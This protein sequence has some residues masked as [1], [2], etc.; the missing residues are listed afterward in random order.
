MILQST[1]RIISIPRVEVERYQLFSNDSLLFYPIAAK[2]IVTPHPRFN[3]V[4]IFS[5]HTDNH[6]VFNKLLINNIV[7]Q[8]VLP[9]DQR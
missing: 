1:S 5:S 2:A 7:R 3:E 9:K 6:F 4:L 8:E